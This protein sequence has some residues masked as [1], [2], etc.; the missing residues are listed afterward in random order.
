MTILAAISANTVRRMSITGTFVLV[1]LSLP[2]S[3]A[4]YD[5]KPGLWQ[6]TAITKMTGVPEE[7]SAMLQMPPQTDQQCLTQDDLLFESDKECQ[8]D[9]QRLSANKVTL[10][11]AC[12]TDNGPVQGNGEINFHGTTATGWFSIKMPEGPVGPFTMKT[13]FDGKYL[14][15]CQ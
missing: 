4:D 12:S 5:F 13:T 6:T 15:P 10:T 14:G 11:V 8:F 2:V 9:K 3:A 7:M 1:G